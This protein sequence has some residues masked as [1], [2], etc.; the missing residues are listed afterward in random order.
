[1]GL[2]L[3]AVAGLA[4]GLVLGLIAAV[5]RDRLS[6]TVGNATRLAELT[7]LEVLALRNPA[8]REGMRWIVRS[9]IGTGGPGTRYPKAIGLLGLGRTPEARIRSLLYQG[10]KAREQHSYSMSLA[11]ISPEE[12]DRGWPDSAA[13]SAW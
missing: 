6:K 1:A 9:Q 12:L 4:G 5:V 11:A 13:R 7:G 8:D 3:Y 10:L 2:L